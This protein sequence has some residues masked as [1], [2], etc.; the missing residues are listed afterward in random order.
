MFQKFIRSL[1]A[2]GISVSSEV[3]RETVQNASREYHQVDACRGG[4]RNIM[5]KTWGRISDNSYTF[6]RLIAQA[7]QNNTFSVKNQVVRSLHVSKLT[8]LHK[9]AK[10]HAVLRSQTPTLHACATGHL[11]NFR[12]T[13]IFFA[14]SDFFFT[15]LGGFGG[16]HFDW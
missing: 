9:R 10:P 3:P 5:R 6:S 8:S 14:L 2:P 4:P 1:E 16:I 15:D 13:R 12:R 7:T 11:S